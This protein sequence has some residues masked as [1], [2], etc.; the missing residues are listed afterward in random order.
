MDENVMRDVPKTASDA[1][2]HMGVATATQP[3]AALE[4]RKKLAA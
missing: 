1:L 4:E 2:V 3:A